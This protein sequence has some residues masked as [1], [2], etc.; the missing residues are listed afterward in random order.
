MEADGTRCS[1]HG[2]PPR[3]GRGERPGRDPPLLH[4]GDGLRAGEGAGRPHRRSRRLGQ[5]RLLRHRRGHRGRVARADRVLGAARRPHGDVRPRHLHRARPRAVGEPHRVPRPRPRRHREPQEALARPR[6]RRRGD[7]PRLLRE[8]LHARPEPD[9]RGV[10]HRHRAV[11]RG[12]PASTPSRCSPTATPSSRRPRTRSST[13]RPSEPPRAVAAAAVVLASLVACTDDDA[14]TRHHDRRPHQPT[15]VAPDVRAR[16]PARDGRG[17]ARRASRR[18][19]TSTTPSPPSAPA[20]TPP[21]G[22][23]PAGA[24]SSGFTRTPAGRVGDRAGVPLRRRRRRSLR[25][26]GRGAPHDLQRRARRHRVW[27]SPTSR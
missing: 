22:S 4:G 3:C 8:H 16:R 17:P 21:P 2:V 19:R 15:T 24:P 1:R 20:R 14:A 11:H 25:R 13:S 23:A 9:P 10:L 6:P 27:P 5:A 26:A 18:T 7:R 12:R